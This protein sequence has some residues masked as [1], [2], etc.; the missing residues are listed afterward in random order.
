MHAKAI[1]TK[2]Y[3]LLGSLWTCAEDESLLLPGRSNIDLW[4]L[5]EEEGLLEVPPEW[6]NIDLWV[7]LEGEGLLEVLLERPIIDL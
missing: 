5:L 2:S 4:V 1:L 7:L 6:P 3:G